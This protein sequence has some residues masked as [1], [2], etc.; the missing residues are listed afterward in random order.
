MNTGEEQ[1]YTTDYGDTGHTRTRLP[2]SDPYGST[3]RRPG[4]SSSRGLITVVGV[5]V[6]LIAAIAF[7]NRGGGSSTDGSSGKGSAPQT[8]STAASGTRPVD[9]KSGGI[10]SGFAHTKQGAQSAAANYAVVL[11]SDGMFNKA[12][13]HRI[14]ETIY[15]PTASKKLQGAMD[16][17][18]SPDFLSKMG[19]D[20][21][22]GPPKGSTFVSRTVPI[23]TKVVQYAN[24]RAEVSVWYM[25][26]IGM[27]GD[28]STN[29]VTSTW[30][31]WTCELQWLNGDWKI[32]ADSQ[33]DGPAPVP[34]DDKAASSDDISK[35]IE[36]YGGFTY[37][38]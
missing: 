22:G 1:G 35:A 13:R 38:R 32:L 18:Y 19:L 7:A 11:G 16:G 15:T 37:A 26:L 3:P 9:T 12:S 24:T 29:P 36:Q 21:N 30:K 20:A 28:S 4:R 14:V 34:G 5:V 10:P 6:L 2:E 8:S 23:G 31:T 27:S 17:A 33:K 25:G